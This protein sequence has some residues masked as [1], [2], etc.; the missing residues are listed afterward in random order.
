MARPESLGERRERIISKAHCEPTA[1]VSRC[2]GHRENAR[3]ADKS[4]TIS[5]TRTTR[6]GGRQRADTDGRRN[7]FLFRG[8]EKSSASRAEISLLMAVAETSENKINDR[9]E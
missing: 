4:S 1:C 7:N 9:S 3:R 8:H 2:S 6:S 5:Y